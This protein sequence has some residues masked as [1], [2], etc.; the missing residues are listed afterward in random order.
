MTRTAGADVR[1]DLLTRSGRTRNA[2]GEGAASRREVSVR[3]W[4]LSFAVLFAGFRV[5]LGAPLPMT[6]AQAL[7]RA[8][9]DNP[10]LLA[11]R[12]LGEEAQARADAVARS[13]RPRLSVSL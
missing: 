9:R 3:R 2:P 10:E 5:A 13:R 1:T 8:D 11:L 12:A 4:W 7:E 6:L